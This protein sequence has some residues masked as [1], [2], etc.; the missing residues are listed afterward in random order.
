MNGKLVRTIG[1]RKQL[2]LL[3][4]QLLLVQLLA[5]EQLLQI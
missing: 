3:L 1:T 5:L 4:V 2:A